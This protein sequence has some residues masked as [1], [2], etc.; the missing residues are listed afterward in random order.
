MSDRKAVP[1]KPLQFPA[2]VYND[3]RD[4]LR[5]WK[6]SE[7]G[8]RRSTKNKTRDRHNQSCTVVFNNTSV[9]IA[10][11][12]VF[13]LTGAPIANT[14]E[15][16]NYLEERLL[17]AAAT[18][19]ENR[20]DCL[21]VAIEPIPAG[22]SGLVAVSGICIAFVEPS[23]NLDNMCT[24]EQGSTSFK[25]SPDGHIPIVH[26]LEDDS[27]TGKIKCMVNLHAG[28]LKSDLFPVILAL[29]SGDAGDA[30]TKCD[31][32]Y[33]V[34][35]MDLDGS[36]G[37]GDLLGENVDP[38]E[39]GLY[40][41]SEIG[42]YVAAERGIA[43]KLTDEDA[44][45]QIA[46]CNEVYETK[47]CSSGEGDDD[48]DDDDSGGGG[49]SPIIFGG[50]YDETKSYSKNTL[51]LDSGFQ[52]VA[53]TT[54]RERP[55]PQPIGEPTTKL[56]TLPVFANISGPG[57]EV[58][59][60]QR[61]TWAS[62]GML[63]KVKAYV[64]T[65]SGVQYEVW[66]IQNSTSSAPIIRQLVSRFTADSTGWKEFPIVQLFSSGVVFDVL[67]VTTRSASSSSFT[68]SWNY[69]S[70]SNDPAAGY[71][72]HHPNGK[73][74]K[75]HHTDNGATDRKAALEAMRTGDTITLGTTVWTIAKTTAGTS[76]HTFEV[77]PQ[78]QHGTKGV[79]SF[80]FKAITS[81]TIDYI[82]K[83]GHF[84]GDSEV[85]GLLSTTGYSNVATSN[86]AFGVDVEY[87]P[88]SVS[89]DWN[90]LAYNG[91]TLGTV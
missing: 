24:V 40:Q 20:R 12:E 58:I 14:N 47:I 61:Y 82:T 88:M 21:C 78:V 57:L 41:R 70:N 89:A 26:R 37:E 46:W 62:G 49:I 32:K 45:V 44:S 11:Y 39:S 51:V 33:D 36:Y 73:T 1:G 28:Y 31:F 50:D 15:D 35:S 8:R 71:A 85:Q 60:G 16:E 87:Q 17:Y 55:A 19:V 4:M 13:K 67:L 64:P 30:K 74:L 80:E 5:W 77:L 76:I 59:T 9:D 3:M 91:E 52:M 81:G 7:R 38:I 53:Q 25:E 72:H 54:T 79:G 34:Y 83:S 56:G 42:K 18:G 6:N 84:S 65:T 22:Q 10:P 2:Q 86:D 48:D 66:L 90:L 75:I 68:A 43:Y 69:Q 27:D 63:A 23:G 29:S